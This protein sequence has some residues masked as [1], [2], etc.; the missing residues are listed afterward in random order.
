MSTE[1]AIKPHFFSVDTI[2]KI[3]QL[4]LFSHSLIHEMRVVAS[5]FPFRVNEYVVDELI[6]WS[7][8]PEDPLFQLSFPQKGMLHPKHFDSISH[9]IRAGATK[10]AIEL[11]AQEIRRSLNPHPGNQWTEN[12]PTVDG[13]RQTGFQHKYKNTALFFPA[14]GQTCYTYCTFCFRWAQF[15]EI[16]DQHFG[17]SDLNAMK[18]YLVQ[19]RELTDILFTGG[20]PMIMAA[21]VFGRYLSVLLDPELAHIRNVRIGTKV[22]AHWPQKLLDRCEGDH[23]FR[24][25]DQ[26]QE[27]GKHVTFMAHFNHWRELATPMADQA[28]TKVRA[29]GL[30][31]R[32]QGPVLRHINDS[33]E[34]WAKMWEMQVSKGLWP[35]YM[36]VERDTGPNRYFE[37]SLERAHEIYTTAAQSGSGLARTARGPV[38]STAMGKVEIIGLTEIAGE[39]IFV[40]RYVQSRDSLPSYQPFFAKYDP[41]ATWLEQLRP[42]FATAFPSQ[43]P[44]SL[45]D[46]API[47]EVT[48]LI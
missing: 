36:F 41:N 25:F 22:L 26:L 6:D 27:A 10:D 37:V 32:T 24:V 40:L 43:A 12:V 17:S 15:V 28:L 16:N 19:H 7:N 11:A 20:D 1:S 2:E 31:I 39:K 29:A 18:A 5:V 30:H 48:I 44:S 9:L 35:Y 13:V 42:A 34:V 23:L 45:N 46:P 38:M 21:K 4:S 3:P 8:V 47:N 14:Q 33:G